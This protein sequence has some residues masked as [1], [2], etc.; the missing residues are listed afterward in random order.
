MFVIFTEAL[1]RAGHT[2]RAAVAGLLVTGLLLAGA[3]AVAAEGLVAAVEAQFIERFT[4]FIEWP[5]SSSVADASV[6]FTVG[7]LGTHDVT[8]A[9]ESLSGTTLIKGKPLR[10]RRLSSLSGI[11]SCQV[12]FVSAAYR[13]Q[14]AEITAT[15][16][17][18]P[19]LT[20]A[21][22]PGFGARGVMINF[23]QEGDYIRFELN[24]R[25]AQA[26]KLRL[27]PELIQ[28]GKVVQ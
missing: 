8:A 28:L 9:L 5:A 24:A 13:D 12:L 10:V 17:G 26:S 7:V 22:T 20:V 18:R 23:F 27:A 11:T 15:V 4:R 3:A 25:A 16:S 1:M 14:L 19:I 2:R 21:D 6:P